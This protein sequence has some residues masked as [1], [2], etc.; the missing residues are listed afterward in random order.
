MQIE[1]HADPINADQKICRSKKLQIEHILSLYTRVYTYTLLFFLTPLLFYIMHSQSWYRTY[2]HSFI[3]KKNCMQQ[4]D[5]LDPRRFVAPVTVR[6]PILC[7]RKCTPDSEMRKKCTC[8]QSHHWTALVQ[9]SC[10]LYD[11][12]F[13]GSKYASW[14]KGTEPAL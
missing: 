3:C 14:P 2:L 7:A 4:G 5:T 9:S 8:S 6:C 12:I 10:L 11:K 1:I 13:S